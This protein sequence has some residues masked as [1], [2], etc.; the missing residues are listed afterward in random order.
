[1]RKVPISSEHAYNP[2]DWY[3]WGKEAFEKAKRENKP[4][5]LSIGYSSCH[6]CHV[7]AK[8]SLEDRKVAKFLNQNFVSIKV[9]REERPD[10]D[11]IYMKAVVAMT[12][13]G[14]SA[15]ERILDALPRTFLR[16]DLLSSYSSIRDASPSRTS[17]EVFPNRGNPKAKENCRL[18]DSNERFYQRVVRL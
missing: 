13:S 12:G 1:M 7:M 5:F 14:G 9:D 11:E 16:W 10:V 17:Y 8:E 3:P 2:V 15:D 18:G 6:W 4:I